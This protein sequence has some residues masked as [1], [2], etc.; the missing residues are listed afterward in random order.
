ML[1]VDNDCKE[2]TIFKYPRKN[3]DDIDINFLGILIKEHHIIKEEEE[4]EISDHNK[5]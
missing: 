3:K 4:E 2:D 1:D 5:S